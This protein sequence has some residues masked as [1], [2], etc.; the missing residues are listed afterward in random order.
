MTP[1][2]SEDIITRPVFWGIGSVGEII[3]YCLSILTLIIFLN[4]IRLRLNRYASGREDPTNRLDNLPHRIIHSIKFVARNTGQF[5]RDIYAGIMHTLILWGFLTLTIGTTI[6]AVDM[7]LYRPL[8]KKSFF[9]GDFYLVYSFVMDALG[10]LLVIGLVMAIYRRYWVKT[11]RLHGKHTSLEDDLFIFSLLYLCIGGYLIEGVR[12][13]GLSFPSFEKV[14]FVGWFVALL[15]FK[16]GISPLTS[17]SLYPLLWW[18]HAIIALL[19]TATIPYAKPFHMFSSL[20]NVIARDELSG[21][22]LPRIPENATPAEIG[23]TTIED[24][25]WKQLLD[26]DACTK[27]GRCSAVCPAKASGRDLD[28]RDVI[29][30]LK[31][32]KDE[33]DSGAGLKRPIISDGGSVISIDSMNSCMSCLACVDACPVGIEHVTQFTEM[34]RRLVE[35]GQ[36]N[37]NLQP[38]MT[39]IFTHGNSFGLPERKRPE[40]TKDLPFVIPDARDSKVQYLWYVGDLPSYDP[41]NQKIAKALAHI[42]NEA[43][44]SYGILYDSEKNDGNDVRRVGEEGLY[45]MLAETNIELFNQCVFETIVCTDPHSYNTIKNEYP[46][47]GFE[48]NVRHYTSVLE[49]LVNSGKLIIPPSLDYSVTYHDPCHLGR[50]NHEY[51]S[52]RELIKKTGCVLHEMPRNRKSSFCCGGG[53]G[54]LWMDFPDT[55]KPSE[56]RLREALEDT[57][58]AAEK[59]VVSCPQCM[60]MYE[61]GRKTGGFEDQI[62]IIDVAELIAEAILTSNL[63]KA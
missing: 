9:V 63:T 33:I 17:Q 62:K 39:D 50:Y 3:F 29:L 15:L 49:D 24:F 48:T 2:P 56:E 38:I 45:E 31:R 20:A 14:S 44:I 25:S 61:D 35:S 16:S 42:F 5:D 19:F 4:G 1:I 59:F 55:Q 47:F 23:P 13:L 21:I 54:G 43:G 60:V 58:K 34:N 6:L 18:S 51:E 12:I 32:Y 10:F 57:Q 8:T 52:P 53:G 37:E 26:H 46:Q 30:D 27:C 40:W 41:R 22:R 11:Q 28:P 36:L 7:D